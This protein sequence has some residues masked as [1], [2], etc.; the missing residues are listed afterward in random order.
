[1]LVITL[2][3]LELVHCERV[4]FQLRNFDMVFVFKDYSKKVAMVNSVPM[5]SLDSVKEWLK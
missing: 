3:E 5:Q 1:M 4:S 2:D